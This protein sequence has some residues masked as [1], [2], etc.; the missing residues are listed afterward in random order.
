MASFRA[1][2]SPCEILIDCS[3]RSDAE[4]IGRIAYNEAIRIETAFSRYRDDNTLHRINHADGKPVRV[5]DELAQLLDFASELFT[6]S[7]GQFDITSG[8]LRR[9]WR[10]EPGATVPDR[11]AVDALLPLIGWQKADWQRPWLT[12]PATMQIDLGGIGKEYAVDRTIALIAQVSSVPVLVNFGGDLHASHTR[13]DNKPWMI[14]IEHPTPDRQTGRSVR[15]IELNRGALTTSGDAYRYI[16][17]DGVR[18]GHVLD[19]R[20]GWPAPGAPRSVTVASATC[21]EAGILSTLAMLQ[22]SNAESFLTSQS[23]PHWILR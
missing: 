3:T 10:F 15:T 7:N 14:G 6:L 9:A 5:D 4:T 1:M 18:Y 12:L 17:Q 23:V 20:T 16:E 11:T 22:G 13:R 19:P 2:A 8:V 21:T